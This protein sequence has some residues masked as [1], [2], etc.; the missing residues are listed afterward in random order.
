MGFNSGLKGL[1]GTLYE[2]VCS[3][4]MI[5]HTILLRMINI[6]EKL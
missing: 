1:M 3:F 4:I 5:P 2:G 6:S